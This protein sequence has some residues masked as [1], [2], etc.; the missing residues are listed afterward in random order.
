M[1]SFR[2][3]AILANACAILLLALAGTAVAM[4]S[5]IVGNLDLFGPETLFGTIS[6]FVYGPV[7]SN[8][9][10][11]VWSPETLSF[12]LSGARLFYVVPEISN[13]LSLLS[14]NAAAL[15]GDGITE[16]AA[17]PASDSIFASIPE[18][19]GLAVVV[20][21]V[22]ALSFVRRRFRWGRGD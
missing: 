13:I 9:L 15:S 5:L 12:P 4:P 22:A 14:A 8:S 16:V 20:S 10:T 6:S 3:V 2:P 18:P 17:F 21:G 11:S 19:V 1:R 7:G